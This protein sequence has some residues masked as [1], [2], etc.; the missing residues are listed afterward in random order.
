M[1]VQKTN[2]GGIKYRQA[3][4]AHQLPRGVVAPNCLQ[5]TK[6]LLSFWSS[7]KN[8][9]KTLP[10]TTGVKLASKFEHQLSHLGT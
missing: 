5:D 4:C 10:K 3:H 2:F 6:E 7:S 8:C 1:P 9:C